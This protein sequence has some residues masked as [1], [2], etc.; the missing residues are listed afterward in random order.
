MIPTILTF[1]S[2]RI[3]SVVVTTVV[4]VAAVPAVVVAIHG[5]TITITAGSVASSSRH[6]DEDERVQI[7]VE[8]KDAAKAVIVKLNNQETSCDAKINQLA[9]KSKLSATVTASVLKKGRDDYHRSLMPFVKEVE[10]D[11]DALENL[12]VITRETAQT[13]LVRINQVEVIALGEDGHTGVLITVCQT[14]IIRIQQI[15]VVV[16]VQPGE[17]DEDDD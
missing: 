13:F 15:L 1:F 9:A 8:V 11:E 7:I 2:T 17:G 14:I 3:V 6:H 16:V 5:H 12:T 4:V 10:A